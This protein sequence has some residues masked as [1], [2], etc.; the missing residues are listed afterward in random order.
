MSILEYVIQ[1]NIREQWE[2]TNYNP[3]DD[4]DSLHKQVEW[5]KPDKMPVHCDSI[6]Q[7][8]KEARQIFTVRDWDS[9]YIWCRGW[10][11]AG[12]RRRGRPL[13]CRPDL[14]PNLGYVTFMGV[15]SP[16]KFSAVGAFHFSI[17]EKSI[18]N[19]MAVGPVELPCVLY[20]R[21]H[22]CG[23]SFEKWAQVVILIRCSGKSLG[24]GFYRT[25]SHLGKCYYSLPERCKMEL[26]IRCSQ[27]CCRTE[28]PSSQNSGW[29]MCKTTMKWYF[30]SIPSG[31]EFKTAFLKWEYAPEPRIPLRP[32]RKAMLAVNLRHW[33]A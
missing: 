30:S 22:Q 17:E 10:R 9:V 27:N 23:S 1:W 16:R 5:K 20:W 19:N 12:T 4:I 32:Y 7:F 26:I 29:T 15:C 8:K 25:E 31:K 33:D 11:W 3:H 6:I 28:S 2:W 13:G 24:I 18:A 14:Y 21:T